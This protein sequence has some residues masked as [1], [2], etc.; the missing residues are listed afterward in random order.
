MKT[1]W[2]DEGEY[3]HCLIDQGTDEWLEIRKGR[4]TGTTNNGESSFGESKTQIARYIAGIETKKFT[5]EQ[6]ERMN[7]GTKKEPVAR[8][9]YEQKYNKKVK[10]MGICIPKSDYTMG[11]SVDGVVE[12]ENGI[13][14]IKCPQRMYWPLKKHLKKSN[15]KYDLGISGPDHIWKS[16]YKQMQ[17]GMGVLR[18]LWCDYIVY[19]NDGLVY[20]ERIYFNKKFWEKLKNEIEVFWK[21]YVSPLLEKENKKNGSSYPILPK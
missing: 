20:T 17:M 6:L 2:K 3:W 7:H 5:K 12:N 11:V 14:E 19:A 10:E 21:E 8:R 18:K 13:I 4:C 15:D 9:W 1:I 16:H